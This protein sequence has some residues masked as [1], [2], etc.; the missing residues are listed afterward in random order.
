MKRIISLMLITWVISGTAADAAGKAHLRFL[1]ESVPDGLAEVTWVAGEK[2]GDGFKLPVNQLSDPV[3]VPERLIGLQSLPDKRP[4]A[5]ITLPEVGDSFVVL[6]VPETAGLLKP[7]VI[8]AN[9][10]SFRT[11]DVFLYNHTDRTILGHL[12]TTEFELSPGQGKPVRPVTEPPGVNYDVG[13]SVRE[14][15]GDR[16]LRTMRWPVQ[17]RFRS[18]GFFAR[19]PARNRIE[20]RSVDEFV[21]PA[22]ENGAPR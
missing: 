7:V 2:H 1:L 11:G 10:P 6:L 16:V 21:I 13:F 8:P 19:N 18:Y 12:G 15:A 17:T 4:L 14:D 5:R 9:D 20:F 3:T 22:K